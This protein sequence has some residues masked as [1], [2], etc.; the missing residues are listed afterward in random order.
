MEEKS[1]RERH[2]HRMSQLEVRFMWCSNTHVC[3]HHYCLTATVCSLHE[4]GGWG[5]LTAIHTR[6]HFQG[7]KNVFLCKQTAETWQKLL[8]HLK[9]LPKWFSKTI[10]QYSSCFL[11]RSLLKCMD[12]FS[13][14]IYMFNNTNWCSI[15]TCSLHNV[16]F[17]RKD[18]W[19]VIILWEADGETKNLGANIIHLLGLVDVDQTSWQLCRYRDRRIEFYTLAAA[20]LIKKQNITHWHPSRINLSVFHQT[21]IHTDTN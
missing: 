7:L 3:T 5:V 10:T 1:E 8:F 4:N 18:K 16:C 6:I 21:G 20:L 13:T 14:Q 19:N 11:N 2:L 9:T 15:K 12:S 17:I